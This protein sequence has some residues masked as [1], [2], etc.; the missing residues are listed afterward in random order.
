[1]AARPEMPQVLSAFSI[2]SF[3]RTAE[4]LITENI[5]KWYK[6]A[7]SQSDL[8]AMLGYVPV[9]EKNSA[10]FFAP[11]YVNLTDHRTDTLSSVISA[12][13]VFARDLG[14]Q[15]LNSNWR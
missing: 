15:G 7:P 11:N 2:T 10:F 8:N 4:I 5:S 1:M 3:S 6:I 14:D 13:R 12:A 9:S